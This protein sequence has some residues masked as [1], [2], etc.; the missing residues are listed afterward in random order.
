MNDWSGSLFQTGFKIAQMT[1][2]GLGLPKDTLSKY[3]I[4][5]PTYLS[6]P[7][8]DL[9][10]TKVDDM[11]GA[12]HRDFDLFTVHGKCGYAGLHAWLL[13]GERFAVDVP[14]DHFLVQGGKQL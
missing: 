9:M 1:A 11:I 10:A 12:F 2:I 13:T 5:G 6:P 3:I 8:V 7:A 4:N 14:N